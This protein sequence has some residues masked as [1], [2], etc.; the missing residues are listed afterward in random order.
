MAPMRFPTLLILSFLY[1]SFGHAAPGSLERDVA[2]LGVKAKLAGMVAEDQALRQGSTDLLKLGHSFG[3]VFSHRGLAKAIQTVDRSNTLALKKIVQR[4]GWVTI[5]KFGPIASDNAWIIA[6]HADHDVEFQEAAL[7]LMTKA[8]ENNDVDR[9]KAA[10]LWDRVK[11]NR[12]LPQ[13]YGSQGTCKGKGKWE[14]RPLEDGRKL[15][16]FR[17]S[18]GLP[19]FADYLAQVSP[20]CQ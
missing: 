5:S 8:L 9:G 11:V 19:P 4:W 12:G 1:P 16:E 3:E 15:D 14:P 18:A 6:Q 13:R 10:Y 7:A 17:S 2:R 20:M